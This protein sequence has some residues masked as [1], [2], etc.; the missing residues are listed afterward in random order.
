MRTEV[1]H[2]LS[3]ALGT[4]RR[5]N[6]PN[7]GGRGTTG[8]DLTGRH[9]PS[10]QLTQPNSQES[11]RPQ[12]RIRPRP[13]RSPHISIERIDDLRTSPGVQVQPRP[14]ENL[15]DLAGMDGIEA[16]A[17][18]DDTRGKQLELQRA[19]FAPPRGVWLGRIRRRGPAT[20]LW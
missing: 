2:R 19:G 9:R 13:T 7:D 6:F 5:R 8:L 4:R 17:A 20:A 16:S 14:G 18:G 10:R 1:L 12:Q 11:S 3:A 15:A